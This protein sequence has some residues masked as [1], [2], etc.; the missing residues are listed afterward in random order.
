MSL[1]LNIAFALATLAGVGCSSSERKPEDEVPRRPKTSPR[2]VRA[3]Q[4]LLSKCAVIEPRI[5]ACDRLQAV[6][7]RDDDVPP[8]LAARPKTVA[9]AEP[10][11]PRGASL[12]T[13]VER[14]TH[15]RATLA[16]LQSVVTSGMR[17]LEDSEPATR[18]AIVVRLS[19]QIEHASK[20]LLSVVARIP[21]AAGPSLVP[22]A[23]DAANAV[24]RV[25]AWIDSRRPNAAMDM[26]IRVPVEHFDS[27][28]VQLGVAPVRQ[29]PNPVT[30]NREVDEASAEVSEATANASN[31]QAEISAELDFRRIE[32][33][34]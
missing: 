16:E 26:A 27:A 14:T 28:L 12:A 2:R 5:P 30:I 32:A 20:E 17:E 21:T 7:T 11:S 25:V 15:A 24:L 19:T 29:R 34:P 4:E 13:P 1:R 3:A 31:L 10:Y 23:N 8:S 22:H 6:V 33:R 9:V 18:D